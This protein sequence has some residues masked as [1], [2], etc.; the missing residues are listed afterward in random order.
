M[1]AALGVVA[2]VGLAIYGIALPAPA[3]AAIAPPSLNLSSVIQAAGTDPVIAAAGDIAC[4]PADSKFNGG[5]GVSNGCRQMATSNLLVG[6][7]LSAVLALGDN[8]Y[9]CGSYGAFTG[10]YDAS[11]GR[12][13]SITHPSVG[14]HEYLTNGGSGASTGCDATNTGAAGYY[15]YFGAAAGDP[16]KGYYSF[17]VGQWHLVALNTQCSSVGGCSATSPQGKWLAADLDAHLNQ[18]TLA[19]FHIPLFSS[20]GRAASN[21]SGMWQVLYAH[22]ADVILNGHDHIYERFAPQTPVG[23]VDAANGIREFIVGTG[24]ANNTSLASIAANSE[25]RDSSTFG[26]LALTLHPGGYNWNFL[27]E[28]GKTFTDSGSGTCHASGGGGGGTA[29]TITSANGVTFTA[30]SA[31]TFTVATTGSPIPAITKTGTLPSG[32]TFTDNHNGTATLA[33]TPPPGTNG[34]YPLTITAANGILPNASQSFTLTVNAGAP[35]IT[36]PNSVTFT[37]GSAGTFTVMTAGSPVPGIS[38]TGGLPGGV[39][40]TDNHNGTA[41]LAGTPVTRGTYPLTITAANGVLPNASQSFTLTTVGGGG[42]GTTTLTPIADAKVDASAPTTNYGSAA[43]RVDGSPIV[44]SYLKFDVSSLSG[45]VQGATLRIWATSAQSLGFDVFAVGDSSWT[46]TG[47]TYANQPSATISPTKLG[48]SGT[49]AAGTWKTIDVTA[50]I[51]TPR[52]YSLV[53]ETTSST[54]LALS[55]REDVAHAPQLVVTLASASATIPDAPTNVSAT[56][57]TEQAQV[58]WTASLNNGGSPITGYVI[59]RIPGGG[60]STVGNLTTATVTGLSDGTSY[61]FT[62][63]ATNIAGNGP[64]S[65]P[66]APVIPFNATAPTITSAGSTTFTV[67]SAG[68][69]TVTTSGTSP[70][71]LSESGALPSSVT[72]TDNGDG[73]ATL[74]GTPASGTNG[75]Y[76]LTIGATNGVLPD[77][78]QSFTLTVGGGGGTVTLLPVA[79][80]YTDSSTPTSNYGTSTSLRFDGSPVVRSYLRFDLSGVSGTITRATLRVYAN[81]ASS[82][83]YS[84]GGT[85]TTWTESGLTAA[86]AP[87]VGASV[88]GSGSIM[89]GSWTSVD[90]TA[91]LAGNQLGLALSGLNATAVRLS[92]R[93]SGAT[94]PQLVL[95]TGP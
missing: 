75:T 19:Y 55:S 5:L 12:V 7:G 2:T 63:H 61:T 90:V 73:T 45:Q 4:D 83:G 78:T 54:A 13:K 62:V 3:N 56:A 51:T 1:D 28:A 74:A 94:A 29:P 20:G 87:S 49:V 23:T 84:V 80:G 10:S 81:T 21:A 95:E 47:L 39:T 37:V 86:N 15:R 52:V 59:T 33:G 22:H 91:L 77:A 6:S 88:G 82:A 43:L 60:T 35:T 89:A 31:G 40:F 8:Q 67:G 46:E 76:P 85:T 66:S 79:D 72:F 38:K 69:F 27:P 24:G 71:T 17:D 25:V 92:S 70:L 57:G 53:L 42:G 68:S 64:E 34:S 65:G 9:Y 30:G 16:T 50:L 36:S 32:V 11:W 44:R 93:E 58:S 26:V 48:S 18:C 14:N 41:T